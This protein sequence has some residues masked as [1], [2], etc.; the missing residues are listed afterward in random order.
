MQLH[1]FLSEKIPQKK[2]KERRTERKKKRKK[3][4]KKERKKDRQRVIPGSNDIS[5]VAP[6]RFLLRGS[7]YYSMLILHNPINPLNTLNVRNTSIWFY[8]SYC[9]VTNYLRWL[10]PARISNSD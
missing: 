4:R 3:E 10:Q 7:M 2:K 5:A 1:R 9:V 6:V 8:I